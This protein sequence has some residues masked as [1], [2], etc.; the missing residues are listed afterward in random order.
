MAYSIR[1]QFHSSLANTVLTDIQFGRDNYYYFLGKLNPWGSPDTPSSTAPTLDDATDRSI[2]NN[3]AFFKEIT[4]NDVSL[5]AANNAWTSGVVYTQWDHTVNMQGTNFFVTTANGAVYKCLF[6]NFAAPSTVMPTSNSYTAFTTADGYLWKYMYT[7]PQFKNTKFSTA[8]LIPVQL[9]LTDG[10]YNTGAVDSIIVTNEGSGYTDQLETYI[11]ISGAAGSGA[12]LIPKINQSTGSIVD[13]IVVNGGSDYNYAYP[14]I[15]TVQTMAGTTPGTNLYSENNHIGTALL[16]PVISGGSIKSVSIEDPGQNYPFSTSTTITV[17]GDGT[18]LVVT[19]VIYNGN[20]IDT[21]IENSGTGY[22]FANFTVNGYG[23]G[24]TLSAVF[25]TSDFTSDQNIVEQSAID[26]AIYASVVTNSGSGYTVTT[27][28]TVVGDGIGA[29]AVANVSLGSIVSV[30]MT[31]YGS[32]YS[33]AN[34]VFSDI[35][36]TG[37]NNTDAV[38]YAILPPSGGHGANAV[39]ELYGFTLAVVSPIKVNPLTTNFNQ[40]YRQYGLVKKPRN[41]ANNVPSTIGFDSN[42]YQVTFDNTNN[43]EIDQ[44]LLFKDVYQFLVVYIS[45]N[46]VY[47]QPLQGTGLDPV[48]NLINGTNT[49]VASNVVSR[50]VINKYS[51]DLIY[52]SDELPF[53]FTESQGL[54]VKTYI[55]F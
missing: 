8:S 30:N 28:V 4:A 22:T 34:F 24:A 26:G 16:T 12:V 37:S 5:M 41:V 36:R 52:V 19:P 51:G 45:G 46:T 33:Y 47:L 23:T 31:N 21:V 43:L 14:P 44:V 38:A 18:G 50:P 15:L 10:F 11:T 1:N 20:L 3:I 7:I 2:R 54:T 25:A 53:V 42:T 40:D 55:T 49:Y 17:T 9:A 48:G 27:N 13:V 39:N 6:N 35:N 29:T 32:G